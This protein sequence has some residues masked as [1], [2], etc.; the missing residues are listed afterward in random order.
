VKRRTARLRSD[1]PSSPSCVMEFRL[2]PGQLKQ[3]GLD[4]DAKD[5]PPE[6]L[7]L[8]AVPT[9]LSAECMV[10]VCAWRRQRDPATAINICQFAG[11][12]K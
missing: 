12:D 6:A 3:L 8:G 11:V 4:P 1:L 5:A 7:S 10:A 2:P 9:P